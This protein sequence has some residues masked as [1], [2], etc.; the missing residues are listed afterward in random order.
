M[1]SAHYAKTLHFW[2]SADM[3]KSTAAIV[4]FLGSNDIIRNCDNTVET[5]QVISI[6]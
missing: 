1:T 3:V 2:L 5:Y 6:L 4:I